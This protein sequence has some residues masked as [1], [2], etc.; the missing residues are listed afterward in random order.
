MSHSP[1]QPRFVARGDYTGRGSKFTGSRLVQTSLL[2]WSEQGLIKNV[3]GFTGINWNSPGLT[4]TNGHGSSDSY[5]CRGGSETGVT[6]NFPC[7][8]PSV[9]I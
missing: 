8:S 5:L 1:A 9:K 7:D 4:W 3:A 6:F 2:V